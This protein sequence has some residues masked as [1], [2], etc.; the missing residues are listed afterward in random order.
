MTQIDIF[1]H[2]MNYTFKATMDAASRRASRRKSAEKATQL[3]E[4]LEKRNYR[5]PF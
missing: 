4:K 2:A 1:Y 3:I 5:A